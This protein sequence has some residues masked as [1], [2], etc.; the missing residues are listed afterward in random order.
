MALS[1]TKKI[2][3][4]GSVAFL[5]FKLSQYL[6]NLKSINF[7]VKGVNL[8]AGAF[9]VSITNTTNSYLNIENLTA[10]LI[11][12]GSSFATIVQNTGLAIP[13]RKTSI[14]MIHIKINPLDAAGLLFDFLKSKNKSDF[15]KKGKFQILGT[16]KANNVTMAINE[17]WDFANA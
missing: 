12:N 9:T 16:F 11:F 13:A 7:K 8:K 4:G 17:N 14:L 6:K 2:L 5:A 15:A 10:D 3:I 1:T